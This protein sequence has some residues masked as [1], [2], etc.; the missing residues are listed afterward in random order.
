MRWTEEKVEL[1]TNLM[2]E[3]SSKDAYVIFAKTYPECSKGAWNSEVYKTLKLKSGARPK[4]IARKNRWKPEELELLKELISTGTY[5]ST[6]EE[7][8]KHYPRTYSA[9]I[10]K[11]KD[12]GYKSN[13]EALKKQYK[14]GHTNN[15]Q[16]RFQKGSEPVNK[17][18]IGDIRFRRAARKSYFWVKVQDTGKVD[19]DWVLAQRYFYEKYHGEIP[20]GYKVIFADGDISNFSKENLKIVTNKEFG[21]A[22][23]YLGDSIEKA[24]AGILIAKIKIAMKNLE[25]K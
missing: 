20:E 12:L 21:Y 24:D 18:K 23:E 15:R 7:F 8:Q 9:I 5:K 19:K 13:P 11:I 6:I 10:T 2:K 16:T 1:A 4:N 25:E 17:A 22:R 3:N 14:E